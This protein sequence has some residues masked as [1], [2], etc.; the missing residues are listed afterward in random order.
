MNELVCIKTLVKN[1]IDAKMVWKLL[2]GLPLGRKQ[3]EKLTESDEEVLI[4]PALDE[5]FSTA[6]I[7]VCISSRPGQGERSDG[8]ILVG[9]EL[10]FYLRKIKSKKAK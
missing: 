7:L 1:A 5:Q 6:R 4:E 2:K 9:K 10:E 3:G 8:Y